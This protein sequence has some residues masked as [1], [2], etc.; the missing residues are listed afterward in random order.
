MPSVFA[1]IL[2]LFFTCVENR[3]YPG[4]RTHMGFFLERNFV[5]L[6]SEPAKSFGDGQKRAERKKEGWQAGT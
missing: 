1:G 2:T 5:F 6:F 4:L 3:F